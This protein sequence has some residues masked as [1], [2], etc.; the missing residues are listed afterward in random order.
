VPAC[1]G[2]QTI[3][4]AMSVIKNEA[5]MEPDRKLYCV[6]LDIEYFEEDAERVESL[7]WRLMQATESFS[8]DQC[9]RQVY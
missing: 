1:Q 9:D 4:T 7:L 8:H 3:V 2:K 6:K 5:N